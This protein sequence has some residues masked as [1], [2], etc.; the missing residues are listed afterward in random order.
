MMAELER[1]KEKVADTKAAFDVAE[2]ASWDAA[3]AAYDVWDE[4]ER[5]LSNYLRARTIQLPKGAT[6]QWLN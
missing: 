5:E 1:L 2:A 4:A 6:G 3:D